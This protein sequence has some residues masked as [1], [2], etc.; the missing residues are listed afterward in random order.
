[1][2]QVLLTDSQS[3][4]KIMINLEEVQFAK[5]A[6]ACSSQTTMGVPFDSAPERTILHFKNKEYQG[7]LETI[8]EIFEIVST[9]HT[10]D[11]LLSVEIVEL[12]QREHQNHLVE[13]V[14]NH[15]EQVKTNRPAI[16]H[17]VENGLELIPKTLI[18]S[19][20]C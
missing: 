9:K 8:Q 11:W 1:M 7:V 15:L 16:A 5:R 10:N 6:K 4:D 17:L 2:K 12:A 14:L 19:P 20:I 13:Q 3:G 18:N